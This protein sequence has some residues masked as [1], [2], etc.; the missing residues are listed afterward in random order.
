MKNWSFLFEGPQG[1]GRNHLHL[2][3]ELGGVTTR[4]RQATLRSIS[5]AQ[6][7]Q[8]A[9]VEGDVAMSQ[10]AFISSTVGSIPDSVSADQSHSFIA[11]MYPPP[12]DA[13]DSALA[14]SAHPSAAS[15]VLVS[16]LGQG[17][18]SIFSS[19]MDDSIVGW[20]PV[21]EDP[22]GWH[23]VVCKPLQE[24]PQLYR[25]RCLHTRHS[26]AS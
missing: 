8:R 11:P 23:I 19:Q 24:S 6:Q 7:V 14:G 13:R 21:C 16:R 25:D 1:V 20:V 5:T 15:C 17:F 26:A 3:R 9:N 12:A 4:A 10:C 18:G 2:R 22:S